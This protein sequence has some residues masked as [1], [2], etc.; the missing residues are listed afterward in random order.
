MR[1]IIKLKKVVANNFLIFKHMQLNLDN[2][3]LVMIDGN[4]QSADSFTTNGV[5][6]SSSVSAIVY[7]LYGLTISGQKS[8]EVINLEVG[9]DCWVKLYFDV[10]ETHYR[11]E[12]YRKDKVNHNKIKLFAND[13]EIT[14]SSNAR[15]EALIQKIIGIDFNTYTNAVI[16]SNSFAGNGFMRATDKGK[17]EILNT[18]ANTLI[19]DQ[20]RDKAKDKVKELN[21]EYSDIDNQLFKLNTQLDSLNDKY[22]YQ[23]KLYNQSKNKQSQIK[24]E[25]DQSKNAYLVKKEQI[26]QDIS[27]LTDKIKVIKDKINSNQEIINKRNSLINKLSSVNSYIKANKRLGKNSYYQYMQQVKLLKEFNN[28]PTC[29]VCGAKLDKKHYDQEYQQLS[30]KIDKFK[31][32]INE[33]K[34]KINQA[35]SKKQVIINQGKHLPKVNNDTSQ[36]DQYNSQLSK[37]KQSLYQYK[38]DY[39]SKR[40]VYSNL[41]LDKP[42][43]DQDLADGYTKDINDL[44]DSQ[45]KIKDKQ[46]KFSILATDVFSDT[47]IKNYVFELIIPFINQKANEYLER[48]T[49]GQINIE[50]KTQTTTKSGTKREKMSVDVSNASGANTYGLCSTGEQKRIELAVSFAIQDLLLNQNNLRINVFIYDECFEGLD[51]IGC[52]KVIDI[53]R[54]KQNENGTIYVITHNQYLKPLFNKV[55]TIIKTKDGNSRIEQ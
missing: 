38:A 10:D 27:K 49:N 15:T 24:Q 36:L 18:L 6:K 11:I 12:R 55:I 7:G 28:S 19:Y 21:S 14:D 23:L 34:S 37:L 5:G 29:P 9:K 35:I 46:S 13:Q 22:Q 33:Y 43:Y 39:L 2:Q 52:E 42:I 8:N 40:K 25:L 44:K 20:A 16:Y 32:E 30:Q 47:G 31:H 50:I 4:N 53:L 54:D 17:K 48:L 41:V 3:G 1:K 51:S 45:V 26:S